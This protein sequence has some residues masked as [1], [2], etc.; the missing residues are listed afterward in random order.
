MGYGQDADTTSAI[1][2][3]LA[4]VYWGID[5]IPADWLAGLREPGIVRPLVDRLIEMVGCGRPR[6]D[7]PR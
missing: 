1:A 4:G 3:G 7:K 2:G 5:G 6:S